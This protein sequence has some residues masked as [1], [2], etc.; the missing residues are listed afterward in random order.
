MTF[1]IDDTVSI[2]AGR[3]MGHTGKVI[4]TP[5]G[6]STMY[7]ILIGSTGVLVDGSDLQKSPTSVSDAGQV[8]KGFSHSQLG[9]SIS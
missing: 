2:V 4:T 7:V 6:K 5:T 1:Q 9:E 8:E 3:R